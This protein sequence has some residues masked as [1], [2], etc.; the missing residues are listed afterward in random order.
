MNTPEHEVVD[1]F[2]QISAEAEKLYD[3]HL[4]YHN[5]DHAR[6]ALQNAEVTI[7]ACQA[8]GIP[9]DAQVVRL[10]VVFHDAGFSQDAIALGFASKEA[11]AASLAETALQQ[12]GLETRVIQRVKQAILATHR[13]ATFTTNEEKAVRAADIGHMAGPYE[14][15]VENNRHLKAEAEL[16]S[17]KSISWASW[18]IGTKQIVEWYLGQDIYLTTRHDDARGYSNFHTRARANLERLLTDDDITD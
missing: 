13:D 5:F 10:A 17:G 1:L 14:V 2:S 18:K 9:I 3:P 4:P 16:L 11:Y 6:A 15:F 12:H 8:E 7:I